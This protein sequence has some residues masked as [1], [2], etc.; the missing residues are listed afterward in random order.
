MT[1]PEREE[2]SKGWPPLWSIA[3]ASAVMLI[4]PAVLFVALPEGPIRAGD[5]VF[6][7]ARQTVALLNGTLYA[8]RYESTCVLERRDPLVVVWRGDDPGGPVRAQV[9]GKTAVEF[10]F[11]PPHAEVA[12]R[13]SQVFQKP[14]LWSDLKDSARQLFRG[15]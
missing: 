3:I 10:P 8:G 6:A 15:R 14:D 7:N 11:C 13:P 4:V 2:P 12:V 9:Q 1:E 5:T